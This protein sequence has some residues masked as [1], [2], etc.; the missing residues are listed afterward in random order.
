MQGL[1][2]KNNKMVQKSFIACMNTAMSNDR[3]SPS[4]VALVR[5]RSTVR[6]LRRR[7]GL[8][9]ANSWLK[10]CT[11][12]SFSVSPFYVRN[13]SAMTAFSLWVISSV[14]AT[15]EKLGALQNCANNYVQLP[16]EAKQLNTEERFP[17]QKMRI[18]VCALP[19]SLSIPPLDRPD[20]TSDFFS[21]TQQYKIIFLG[22][23]MLYFV[24][25]IT[26]FKLLLLNIDKC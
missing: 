12:L 17:L 20:K 19:I 6:R 3:C 10:N 16:A 25:I 23:N 11:F 14:N 21:F 7:A 2:H 13:F 4:K 9:G 8:E 5:R 1:F 18:K 15:N 24:R 22:C 26:A